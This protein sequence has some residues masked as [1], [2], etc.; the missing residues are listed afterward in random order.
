MY[1]YLLLMNS[2]VKFVGF[3]VNGLNELVKRKRVL[4]HLKKLQIFRPIAFTQETH[5]T[6]LEQKRREW[7]GHVISSSFN[8]KARV[9]LF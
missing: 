7:V 3:N 6:S 4:T 9:W 2:V 5:L 1:S 8:S